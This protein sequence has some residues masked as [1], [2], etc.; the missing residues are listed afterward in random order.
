M[1]QTLSCQTFKVRPDVPHAF[2]ESFNGKL[3]NECL[4]EHLFT[5]LT[6]A[7]PLVE[8]WRIDYNTVRPH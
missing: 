4:N 1:A 2:V 3:S 6:E 5:S 7:R 8:S